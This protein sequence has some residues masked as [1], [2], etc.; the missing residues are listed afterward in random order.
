MLSYVNEEAWKHGKISTAL[1][2]AKVYRTQLMKHV[3][4][5]GNQINRFLFYLFIQTQSMLFM[6]ESEILSSRDSARKQFGRETILQRYIDFLV[7]KLKE[8]GTGE[9]WTLIWCML[10]L[11]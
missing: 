11:H 5:A 1:D 3:L 10:P 6:Q 8:Q 2:L 4:R 9:L 7:K